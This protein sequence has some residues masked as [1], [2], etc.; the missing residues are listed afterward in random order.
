MNA[1]LFV[2]AVLSLAVLILAIQCRSLV[3]TVRDAIRC[4]Y[5]LATLAKAKDLRE[6][7]A[8]QA[9]PTI[10]E[11]EGPRPSMAARDLMSYEAGRDENFLGELRR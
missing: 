8:Y 10:E 5:D 11:D 7:A 3:A 4:N 6:V 1:D 2:Q 9:R